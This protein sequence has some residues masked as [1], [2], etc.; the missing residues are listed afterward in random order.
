MEGIAKSEGHQLF[1]N[2]YEYFI[3]A[4]GSLWRALIIEP[5]YH[6]RRRGAFIAHADEA[7]QALAERREPNHV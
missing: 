3:H 1:W 4:D 5:I 6:E 7:A 2:G